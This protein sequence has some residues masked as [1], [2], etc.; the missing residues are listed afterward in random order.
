MSTVNYRPDI[1]GLRAEAV[2]AVILFHLDRLVFIAF[3]T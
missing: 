1:K 2:L 3:R